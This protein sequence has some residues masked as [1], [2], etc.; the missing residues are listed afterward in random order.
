LEGAEAGH[1][2]SGTV[3]SANRWESAHVAISPK[4][5]TTRKFCAKAANVFAVGISNRC[6]GETDRLPAIV[7]PAAVHPTVWSSRRAEVDLEFADVYHR[8]AR[9]KVRE[10]RIAD[11]VQDP[12]HGLRPAMIIDGHGT[13]QIVI[14]QSAQVGNSVAPLSERIAEATQNNRRNARYPEIPV[15]VLAYSYVLFSSDESRR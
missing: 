13:T 7:E 2:E 6:F 3:V 4:K 15:T 11:R 12:I 5:R 14:V 1:E 10:K 8:V 9:Y